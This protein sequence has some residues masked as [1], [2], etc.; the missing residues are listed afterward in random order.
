MLIHESLWIK[1]VVENLEISLGATVL[2]FGSQR[3][4][5]IKKNQPWIIENVYEAT[6]KK[7]DK[8]IN[9]DLIQEE[10]V[11]ITGNIFEDKIFDEL[12]LFHFS[13]I[14]VFNV[15]EHVEDLSALCL[16]IE[17]LLNIGGYLIITVPY[18]YP[19]HYDP[20]DNG[21][22][23]TPE[24]IAALF[25]LCKSVHSEIITDNKF[26]FYL[27]KDSRRFLKYVLRLLTPMYKPMKWLSQIALLPYLFKPFKVSGIVLQRVA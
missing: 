1:Q 11:D 3:Y 25:P 24:T 12:K 16:R 26:D 22:R 14:Y 8:T 15:L 5:T 10:G 4:S 6:S 18:H 2:N 19:T 13:V 23:P 9:Y 17:Q 7:F 20:I 27:R 21:F